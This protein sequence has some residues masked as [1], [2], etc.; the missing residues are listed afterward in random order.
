MVLGKF[1]PGKFPYGKFPPIKLLPGKFPP[2]PGKF[3]PRKL[4]P[5]I[6]P[7]ISSIVLLHDF[8]TEY[9]V[10]TWGGGENLYVQNGSVFLLEKN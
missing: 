1:P 4:S 10:H 2:S 3:P 7:P 8:F 6:F 9:F 5:G